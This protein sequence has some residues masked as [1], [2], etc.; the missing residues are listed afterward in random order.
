MP[1]PDEFAEA[2]LDQIS[3]EVNEE[4]EI[5]DLAAK[6]S[7]DPAFSVEFESIE[8]AVERIFPECIRR[9][10]EFT[11]MPVSSSLKASLTE[12]LDFKLLKARKVFV[13]NEARGYVDDLF[14]AV[15]SGDTDKI[16]GMVLSDPARYLVYSTYAK[17]YLSKI[18]TTYGDILDHTVYL[19][20][21]ILS[22]YPRIILYKHGPPFE[23]MAD[24]VRSGYAGALKMTMLEEITHSI[25][26]NLNAIN[27]KAVTSVNSIN[28]DCARMILEMDDGAAA[29]LYDYVQLQTVPDDFPLAKK[30]NLF[31]FLD[32]NFF[33][34]QQLGPDI[35]T[36]T[37]VRIDPKISACAPELAEIYGRWLGPMQEHHAAFTVMEGMAEFTVQSVL[38]DESDFG[39]Y[40]ATFMGADPSSYGVRKSIGRDF[41]AAVFGS[42]G[43]RTFETL[44]SIPPTTKELKDPEAYMK[45][46]SA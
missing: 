46:I 9:V 16:A 23:T 4:K 29:R 38:K 1:E 20:K 25:Q 31:F 45:R 5:A 36:Y 19:N 44:D 40:L 15:A 21:F 43:T 7:D 3:V 8:D 33:L 39:N 34:A 26:K 14:M 42:I 22:S 24:Q 6:I 35:M 10:A 32:P 18:S 17:N 13:T 28:E 2:L 27:V 12:L 41:T 11:G 37:G 30:A